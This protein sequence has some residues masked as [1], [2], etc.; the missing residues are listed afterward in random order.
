MPHTTGS[1]GLFA[2]VVLGAG[3]G[4][5][6]IDAFKRKPPAEGRR[7]TRGRTVKPL[8]PFALLI[9]GTA[10]MVLK[11]VAILPTPHV[12]STVIACVCLFLSLVTAIMYAMQQPETGTRGR[13]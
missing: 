2:G 3:M 13:Q 7:E 12:V 10:E 11:D 8:V 6:L 4:L 1:T 9:L 5:L